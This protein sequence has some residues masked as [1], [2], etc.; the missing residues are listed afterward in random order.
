MNIRKSLSQLALAI[1]LAT[2]SLGGGLTVMTHGY[3]SDVD[4]WIIP[5]AQRFPGRTDFPGSNLTCYIITITGGNQECVATV[6]R[7]GS[8]DPPNPSPLENDSGEIVVKLDWSAISTPETTSSTDV[9]NAAIEALISTD[10]IPEINGRALAE[11]PIHLLGHSRGSSVASELARLLGAEGI[12]VDQ[13][14]L[15]DPVDMPFLGFD[16]N[17]ATIQVWDNVLFAD[18]YY[19]QLGELFIPQGRSVAGCYNRELTNL[20]GGYSF[21]EGGGHSDV[22]AWY[23]GTVELGPDSFDGNI[24]ITATMRDTWYASG[25]QEG[26]A[27]GFHFSR[28]GGGNRLGS[29]RP[30]GP[31]TPM[32]VEGYNQMWDL[33]AG[34]SANRE[35][36][37]TPVDPWPNIIIAA[38]TTSGPLTAGDPL[39]LRIQYQ[40]E[41]T[42]M[43][44]PTLELLLDPDPNPWNGNEIPLSSETL[45]GSG[46]DTVLS[47][48]P[49]PQLSQA[50]DGMFYVLARLSEGGRTRQ[51][52]LREPIQINPAAPAPIIVP[53]SM[54][55]E[56]NQPT[57]TI[58]GTTG[59]EVIIQASTTLQAWKTIAT[60]T[61]E[62]D[63]EDFSDP[64]AEELPARFY[65][66]GAGS[67]P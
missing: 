47:I 28:I 61:L 31:G 19:Q 17:D 25:E 22:H 59:Q 41:V 57:F 50:V 11:L 56:A 10:C 2:P 1:S 44:D 26:E 58:D 29:V 65:R 43:G 9:A 34:V 33:G 54:R 30:A 15:W 52:H 16:F 18:N 20:P 62:T 40:S 8:P 55:F 51:M 38:R 14:T 53:G 27:T 3:N 42:G 67:S 5:M 4:G 32:V 7:E 39:P 66:I 45:T 6:T 60:R 36:L 24:D 64:D 35:P 12:W 37:P 46:F 48:N 21:F 63:L 13:L 49:A 23:H